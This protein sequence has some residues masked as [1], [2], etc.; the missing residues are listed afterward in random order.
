ML[1]KSM[2]LVLAI[3][4]A[5]CCIMPAYGAEKSDKISVKLNSDIAGL[6]EKDYEKLAEIKSGNIVYSFES[7]LPVLIADYAGTAESGPV[8]AGRIYYFYYNFTAAE[9][10]TLP[11]EINDS[12]IDIQCGKG[13]KVIAANIVTAKKNDAKLNVVNY[14][15]LAIYAEVKVDGNIFQRITGFIYDM[16]LKAKAW[17]LY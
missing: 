1:K 3:C 7:G 10:Y 16:I 12:T 4:A 8:K 14:R 15:G 9:G 2:A 5:L 6:T 17:S 13:V 11:D